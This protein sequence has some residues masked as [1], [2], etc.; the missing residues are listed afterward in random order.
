[1]YHRVA[2]L[3]PDPWSLA[4]TPTHFAEQLTVLREA[5]L[6]PV[7]L[8]DLIARLGDG[9][10]FDRSVVVTFDDG[11]ADNLSNAAPLLAQFD[12]PA[13]VFV[14]S[15]YTGQTREFWW[16]TLDRLLTSPQLSASV[17]MQVGHEIERIDLTHEAGNPAYVAGWRASHG[18]ACARQ[19]LYLRAY[20]VL[21][22]LPEDERN[23]VLGA[24]WESA[25][26][27]P[28]PRPEYG[29]LDAEGLLSLN[30]TGLIEIGAHTV[31]HP[32]LPQLTEREQWAEISASQATLGEI[33][34]TPVTAF[35]YPYGIFT[36]ETASLV[37]QAGYA[38][39]CTTVGSA[40]SPG[41]DVFQLPRLMVEDWDG[42]EFGRRLSE[43][44]PNRSR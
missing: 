19:V 40:V 35:A 15:G 43:W 29:Q 2:V 33:I 26:L 30:R 1:M 18:A 42:D 9:R 24:L 17:S 10:P 38:C 27:T 4:V 32:E 14:A 25:G 28:V 5:G 44:L 3:D 11:Y 31:T 13:T 20:E 7:G 8:R 22:P 6:Q 41:S 23:A 39:A 36:P 34:A 37:R 12:V 21:R 16:D